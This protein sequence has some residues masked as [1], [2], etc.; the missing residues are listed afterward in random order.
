MPL[1]RVIPANTF[2]NPDTNYGSSFA[3][4]NPGN[5]RDSNTSTFAGVNS[6]GITNPAC[7]WQLPV[8]T[9]GQFALV[10]LELDWEYSFVGAS[11]V[12]SSATLYW[13]LVPGVTLE[14]KILVNNGVQV[15]TTQRVYLTPSNRTAFYLT[16]KNTGP[17]SGTTT[18]L[19]YEMTFLFV[20]RGVT[21]VTS[22]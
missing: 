20:D 3:W 9:T 5:A 4:S 13:Q 7:R 22:G 16:A 2:L 6:D 8:T 10:G 15:R 1:I 19:I 21:S 14:S 18:F 11:N 12:N 17:V